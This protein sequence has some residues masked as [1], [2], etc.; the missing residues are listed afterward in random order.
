MTFIDL[1]SACDIASV[2]LCDIDRLFQGPIFQ[3]L[4]SKNGENQCK[5]TRDDIC[6]FH[7]LLSNGIANVIFFDL[8]LL[9]TRSNILNVNI[10]KTVRAGAKL[11][12][13]TFVDFNIC[14]RMASLRMLYSLTFTY[15][16][17]SN[18]KCQYLEDGESQR[19]IARGNIYR[20]QH[21]PSNSIIVNVVL[22]DRDLA[23]HGQIFQISISRKR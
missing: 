5:T 9:F 14:H 23:F 15:F 22:F 17:N 3:K 12:E 19:K 11:Q 2:V 20:F 21:L 8:D 18:F 1:Q 10:L 4:I 13:M 16:S 6:R 7:D